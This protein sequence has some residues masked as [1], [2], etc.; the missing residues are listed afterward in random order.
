MNTKYDAQVAVKSCVEAEDSAPTV[1]AHASVTGSLSVRV[2]RTIEE[3]EE[4]RG[5]WSAWDGHPHSDID[6]L[7]MLTKSRNEIVSPYVV[8]VSR[9][10]RPDA[11]MIGRLESRVIRYRVGYLPVFRT[12]GLSISFPYGQLRGNPSEE[13]CR[14][15]VQA[16]LNSLKSGEADIATLNYSDTSGCL[17]QQ[18]MSLP[19]FLNRGFVAVPQLHHLMRLQGSFEDIFKALSSS[20]RQALR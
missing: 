13:N 4:F 17:Y 8:V 19:G 20:Y 16:I 3:L 10:G 18:A 1:S 9:G 11:M 2:L 7:Q 5:P 15:I 14:A 6:F 12:E